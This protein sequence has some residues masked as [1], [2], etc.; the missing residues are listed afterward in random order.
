MELRFPVI[1]DGSTG[2]Q[3]QKRGFDS[4]ICAEEWVLQH[5]EVIREVQ[6]SYIENGSQIVYAPTY[7]ANRVKLESHGIFN[8]VEDY[9]RRLVAISKEAVG[10]KAWVAGDV[11]P[12]G[13][14]LHPLG[15]M[16]FEE[17]VD[18]YTEQ[19]AALEKAGV[20]LFVVETLMTLPEAR[21][22][23]LAIKSISRKPVF[24]TFTCDENGRTLTGTDVTAAL[25]VLQGMGV[26]AFGLNCSSGPDKML[27][28]LR[29]LKEYAQV[30]L[31][32]KPNAGAPKVVDGKTVYDCT[33]EAFAAYV[34][35]MAAC[36][37][38]LFGG[39]CGTEAEHIGQLSEAVSGLETQVVSPAEP[40]KLPCATEKQVFLLDVTA[41][42]GKILPC[43]DDLEDALFDEM[44]EDAEMIAIEIKSEDELDIFADCQGMIGKPLCILCEDA[45]LLEQ[46]LRL[47]Q[48]RAVYEGG[49]S[50]EELMPLVEKYG[51][52]L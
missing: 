34:E 17:L 42:Y 44:E 37:V 41:S 27:P 36:G 47:Y 38:C 25:V 39:C 26:D 14:Y 35:E 20:D 4:S 18:V 7:G 1:L 43:D 48:G 6:Q 51:L 29:R 13:K 52:L 50:D 9:N 15:E 31:I 12:T 21:A 24:V 11:A 19:A 5:P 32:A 22:A 2:T 3:L 8:Q 45:V 10:S 23:V 30:P 33:P 40:D 49:L 28:Q 16:T 46:A